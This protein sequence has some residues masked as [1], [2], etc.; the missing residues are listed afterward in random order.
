MPTA[1]P[2]FSPASNWNQLSN[3]CGT[4]ACSIDNG[5]CTIALSDNFVMGLYSGQIDFSGRMITLWGQGKILDAGGSG[6]LFYS[7]AA[8]SSLELHNAVLQNG[9]SL[10]SGA[11]PTSGVSG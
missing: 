7:A 5:G 9:A 2:T 1:T 8:G 6:I 3:K 11:S 4:S 10:N